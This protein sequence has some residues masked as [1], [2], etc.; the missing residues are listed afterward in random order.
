IDLHASRRSRGVA[1]TF[2]LPSPAQIAGFDYLAGEEGNNE[3]RH[4]QSEESEH[5][6]DEGGHPGALVAKLQE[7]E[8]QAAKERPL[9]LLDIIVCRVSELATHVTPFVERSGLGSCP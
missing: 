8:E 6:R 5:D 7:A 2:A 4:A 9:D 1:L 3:P